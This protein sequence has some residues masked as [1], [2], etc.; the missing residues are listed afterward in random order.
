[1]AIA[2][3]LLRWEDLDAVAE[4][5][6]TEGGAEGVSPPHGRWVTALV[7]AGLLTVGDV[8]RMAA[9]LAADR[10]DLTP[11]LAGSAR[12]W[13]SLA[14]AESSPKTV[15]AASAD[16][17]AAEAASPP[18]ALP[19]ELRFLADWP[20]YRIDR[21]LGS[22]GMGTVFKA[23]DPTLGR[24]VALKFLHR[25][26]E[27]QTERFLREARSQARVTHPNVCQVHEV[28]EAEGRPYI[29][30][31]YIDGRSL[32]ELCDELTLAEK[33]R[34]MR[35][36]AR[37]VHAAHRT[38]LVH[39]DLKPGNILLAREEGGEAGSEIHPYVV[40]F[41]LAMSQDEVSL[42]RTGMVSGTPAYISPEAAQ[43]HP[44][45]RR[46]DVYS[47]GVVLYELLAGTPP[48]AGA[49]LAR[50]LVQLVQDDP[51]PLR[52]VAPAIPEDLETIVAKC[53]EKDPGRRYGSA[54]ELAED[55]DRF[56][57][58][59]PI[60]AR[61][62]GWTY[63]AGKRLRKNK[64]LA[65]VSAGAVLALALMGVFSLRAGW[66]R[67][68][69]AQKFGQRI[70]SFRTS[71]E[72]VA[73]QPLHDITPY[74]RELR[75]EMDSIRAEMKQIG[76]VA[77][78]P[79]NF[80]LGAGFLAL[81]QDDA[82]RGRLRRAWEA[83][84]QG[85]QVAEALGLAYGRAYERALA[86][87]DRSPA[88]EGA[89]RREEAEDTYRQPAVTYLRKALDGAPAAGHLAGLIA[90]YE[91]RYADALADAHRDAAS[92]QTTRAA[93]AMRLAA[94]VFA[95]QA[96]E[97][98]RAGRY[99]EAVGLFDRS[100]EVYARLAAAR[101]SDPDLYADDCARRG[102]RLQA[103][104]AL[105]DVPE[106]EVKADL[107]ACDRAL[108]VDPGLAEGLV[109]E[110][111]LL[112]RLGEQK[113]KRGTDPT[114]DLSAAVRLSTSAIAL[115]PHDVEAR[116]HLAMSH[117]LLAQWKMGRGI[118][119]SAD[120]RQAIEAARGA[121]EVQPEMPSAYDHL[122]T[123]YVVL[124][125][126][127]LRRGADARQ[128]VG[129]AV[130]SYQKAADL[131]PK[132]LPAYIGLGNSW[133]VMSELE[134]NQ[135]SDPSGSTGKGVAALERAAALNPSW[136]AIHNNL[137]N[138]HLTLGE[139]LLTRG[140][141][142]RAALDRAA[143]SYRHAIELKPDYYLARYNLGYT[144]RSLGEALLDPGQDPRPA[145]EPA[146]AALA[147]ATRL[148]PT[149][150]DA[151]LE[152]ARVKLLA[153]RWKQRQK[154]DPEPDLRATAAELARAESLNPQQADVF[155][156]EGL[157]ARCRAET[158]RDDAARAAA[159]REGL[160]GVA[161]ALAVNAGEARYLALRGMFESI[162]A[163]QERD[164]ARRR[165][166]ARQAVASLEAAFKANP[167]LQREYGAALAEARLDTGGLQTRP[168]QL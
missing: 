27:R 41:G 3:G 90:L 162:G 65:A 48:F 120:I 142:P 13:P 51:K 161:R 16:A 2:K 81:H 145:L 121:V 10:V 115:D 31:Q 56:L 39:R 147:E 129:Q 53:L 63:R 73:T 96:T 157:V 23:F 22:G 32:G 141:D 50:I 29:A 143:V 103:A 43:G 62:T 82:A 54:R 136:A 109:V 168:A 42:S 85:P 97:A 88:T 108:K 86:D 100:G 118:D 138:A 24:W 112:S 72:Y 87:A 75:A 126:D 166:R 18:P 20:R 119:G 123:A 151:F 52:Q 146:A 127:Q 25:N 46:T 124:A 156:T 144:W 152:Q 155:F 105:A 37:A 67:A 5:L 58:G 76:P 35:D 140:L 114:A 38:G 1:L 71:M 132:S 61:P 4:H 153:A 107:A 80:A 135:G 102:R 91:G 68:E 77:A 158:A 110:A 139:Y 167:L 60:R 17:A 33:A 133:K 44:I 11:D 49:N 66:Q 134:I 104:I 28:G 9:E 78:G 122:G 101:P 128:A 47:L 137:G 159:L 34:L 19:P 12:S 15:L 57:D 131:N 116:N 113:F 148:N 84:E 125:Q 111:D 70:G 40:D 160:A 163:R 106:A 6:P 55:L 154:L 74:K 95:A 130:A 149:D 83:G 7:A 89:S 21:L 164:P 59:E 99:A 117:R 79:G 26:D 93:Q 8:E 150:A 36:V 165:E 98:A 30:M 64:A 45:D 14:S 92:P 69:L 94:K